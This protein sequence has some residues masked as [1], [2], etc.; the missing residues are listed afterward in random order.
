MLLHWSLCLAGMAGLAQGHFYFGI[1]VSPRVTITGHTCPASCDQLTPTLG[2]FQ[3]LYCISMTLL[4]CGV[5]TKCV[6]WKSAIVCLQ[7]LCLAQHTCIIPLRYQYIL[8]P[9]STKICCPTN[10]QSLQPRQHIHYSWWAPPTST[11][12]VTVCL[13]HKP[14]WLIFHLGAT[15]FLPVSYF[16]FLCATTVHTPHTPALLQ[17]SG[18]LLARLQ[19]LEP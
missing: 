15:L 5:T 8:A 12:F 17:D 4:W 7:L 11:L 6:C 13:L 19:S 18:V 16:M 10:T 2:N 14:C 9:H 1:A 3:S